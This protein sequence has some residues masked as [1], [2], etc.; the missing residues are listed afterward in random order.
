MGCAFT[1]AIKKIFD[2]KT[3]TRI[4]MLGLDAAGKTTVLYQ[5]KL[6]EVVTT[7]P[8]IGFNVESLEYKNL[9]MTVWDIGGQERIR[10]L[11]KDYYENSNGLIWVVDSNDGDRIDDR[12]SRSEPDSAKTELW[13]LLNDDSLRGVPLLVLANK[14]DLPYAVSPQKIHQRLAL[15]KVKDRPVHVQGCVAKTC[16]G[17][18]EGLD[19]LNQTISQKKKK[20]KSK[21]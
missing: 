8:T 11:W 15:D 9:R 13:R 21:K 7:I 4:L 12:D 5:L 1:K 17:L 16:D 14:Q 19:W 3:D 2:R 6:G 10:P 20:G 18:Y